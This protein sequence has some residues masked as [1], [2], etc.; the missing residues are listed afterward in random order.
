[1]SAVKSLRFAAESL[2]LR[3]LIILYFFWAPNRRCCGLDGPGDPS[4]SC[5]IQGIRIMA[6][7]AGHRSHWF[8]V[9]ALDCYRYARVGPQMPTLMPPF[10]VHKTPREDAGRFLSMNLVPQF[11]SKFPVLLRWPA[12]SATNFDGFV[13]FFPIRWIYLI[14][15][16]NPISTIYRNQPS[17]LR[18]PQSLA[19]ETTTYLALKFEQLGSS[20]HQGR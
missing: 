10:H 16:F 12:D 4:D 3:L 7:G 11:V 18:D 14:W 2:P 20:C 1:M 13:V 8:I 9:S 6:V 5:R 15:L 19:W 17:I